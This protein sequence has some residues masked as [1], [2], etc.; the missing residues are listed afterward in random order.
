MKLKILIFLGIVLNLNA[1]AQNTHKID[2]LSFEGSV[3]KNST[4]PRLIFIDVYTDWCGWC[5]RMDATTFKDSTFID[6]INKYFYA[7]KLDAEMADT[8][9]FNNTV[10]INPAPTARRSTHQLAA[11]LLQG[12]MSYPSFVILNDKFQL[13]TII[14]GFK[15]PENINPIMEYFGSNIYLK[16]TWEEFQSDKKKKSANN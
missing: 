16:K 13:L 9:R 14:K 3:E 8:V 2:W 11:S 15:P 12:K 6:Y 5:K 7:V 4:N 1:I 10:F